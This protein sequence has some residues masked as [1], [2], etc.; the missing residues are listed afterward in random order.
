MFPLLAVLFMTACEEEQQPEVLLGGIY[1]VVS[2][3]DTGGPIEG[4][5]ITL[6]PGNQTTVTEYD[7]YFEFNNLEA[8][9]YIMEVSASSYVDNSC[10]I[11]VLAGSIASGNIALQQVAPEVVVTK[12]EAVDLGLSTKWASWNVGASAPEEYGDYY[13]WGETETKSSYTEESYL[14]YKNGSYIDLGA[15]ICGTSYDV[16]HVKWGEEWCMPTEKEFQELIDKCTWQWTS[17]NGVA[18]HK[19]TGLNGNS[20]FLPASG[21]YYGEEVQYCGEDGYFWSCIAHEKDEGDSYLLGFAIDGY[22]KMSSF[23]RYEGFTIRPV[24]KEKTPLKDDPEDKPATVD[25]EA[26]DLGLSVKW[27]VCN[28]GAS[29]PEEYGDYYAWGETETKDVYGSTSYTKPDI[30]DISGTDYDVAHVKWGGDW[31]MPTSEE[32]EEL[33]DKCSWKFTSVNGVYGAVVTGPNGN[34]IFLPAT[35]YRLWSSH[36]SY[37]YKGS[38]WTSTSIEEDDEMK[39]YELTFDIDYKYSMVYETTMLHWGYTIRPVMDKK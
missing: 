14:Y 24:T 31:R 11:T 10:Q 37:D 4:A 35:G 38:Y 15:D 16:A 3:V 18:G 32:T 2:D 34:S 39:A 8:G 5:S 29:A 1:G 9:Q 27:A 30:I 19:V 36:D 17:I 33:S 26:I 21:Y 25:V 13:A 6:T 12:A 7:G 28:V 22:L 20:I 23:H